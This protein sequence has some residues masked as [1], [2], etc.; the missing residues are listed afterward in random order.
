MSDPGTSYRSREEV[1][2]VRQTRDPITQFKERIIS[3]GLTTADE[4]KQIDSK[5][6]A[7]VDEATKASKTDKEIGLPELFT[8]VYGSNIEPLIRGIRVVN[9][10]PHQT[11][12]N[13]VNK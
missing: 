4:I 2:E 5:I 6:K 3:A 11:L 10:H 1:Q 7:E 8:D 13:I 12:N 9:Q